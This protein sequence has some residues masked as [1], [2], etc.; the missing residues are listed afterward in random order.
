MLLTLLDRKPVRFA[1][2]LI[3]L[4]LAL[5]WPHLGI[6]AQAAKVAFGACLLTFAVM[7]WVIS[8]AVRM[9]A[10]DRPGERRLHRLP[11]PRIGGLAVF[12]AVNLT[13]F[14]NFNYSFELK[15][16]CI[17]AIMVMM[18]SLWDDVH[19]IPAAFKLI[20]QLVALAVLA[21]FDVHV[22]FAS[23]VWWGHAAE[24]LVTALWMIGITNAFNFLDGINGMAA[25]LAACI[26]LLMALLAWTTHQGFMLLLCL[27]VA[28]A[29]IGFLPDNARF[30]RPAKIFLGDSG[31]TYLGWMM[32]SI[33]VMGEWSD[34][35]ILYAYSAPVLIFSVMIFDMIYTTIARIYR[36]DVRSVHDWIAYV[37]T[38]HLHH[39]LMQLGLSP[40]QTVLATVVL[41]LITGMAALA[42]VSSDRIAILLLLAQGVVFFALLSFIMVLA[43]R[44]L[45][46]PD[47]GRRESR[48]R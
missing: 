10:I 2:M 32:A 8:L 1:A 40:A 19:E 36:G 22:E 14:L 20:V 17:S 30:Q 39:R 35:G 15:G 42:M 28:G 18:V 13:L 26:C 31:S 21:A 43:A 23:D 11:T 7:P 24:F 37:G 34:K 6:M 9:G 4:V 3:A 16:V 41:V 5:P 48:K 45:A 46:D 47:I 38:D 12:V 27:A 29:A 44:R 25:S 33:A